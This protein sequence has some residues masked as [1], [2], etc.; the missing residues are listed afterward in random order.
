M[1][2]DEINAVIGAGV[3]ALVAGLLYLAAYLRQQTQQLAAHL[4]QVLEQ[5]KPRS[6]RAAV[7]GLYPTW[8]QLADPGVGGVLHTGRYE[9]CGEECVSIVLQGQHGV[10]T[11]AD[12]LRVQ[13]GGAARSPL[14]TATDLVR[15]LSL[16]NVP[17]VVQQPD[18]AH[19]AGDLQQICGAGGV[20]IALGTWLAP[21]VLHWILVTRA[22]QNGCGADDPWGGR[23][24]TWTWDALRPLYAGDLVV[25]T[26][27]PDAR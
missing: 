12:V 4:Q 11:S 6:R 7:G 25:I 5:T 3:A 18:A 13:L 20:A 26:R 15:L 19:L 27:H 23:R 9:E 1:T 22:D 2:Q 21:G 24:R 17:A 16:N 14:T 8:S 10:A